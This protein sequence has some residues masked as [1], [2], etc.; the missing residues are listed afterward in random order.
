MS[1]A[2]HERGWQVAGGYVL[3]WRLQARDGQPRQEDAAPSWVAFNRWPCIGTGNSQGRVNWSQHIPI[4]P[5]FGLNAHW[6]LRLLSMKFVQRL[7][8]SES[9]WHDKGIIHFTSPGLEV[10]LDTGSSVSWVPG[11]VISALRRDIFPSAANAELERKH[12]PLSSSTI[13]KPHF[14]VDQKL[15]NKIIP[16]WHVEYEFWMGDGKPSQ[17]I[18]GPFDQFICDKYGTHTFGESPGKEGIQGLLFEKPT[19]FPHYNDN[20]AIFGINFFQTMFVAMHK[21]EAGNPFV[22]LAPQWTWATD[23]IQLPPCTEI[24]DND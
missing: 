4:S 5:T 22:R 13:T 16:Q 3:F 17:K 11:Y 19:S 2:D 24:P 18:C 14:V 6:M 20:F 21:P 15:Q 9:D 23:E 12:R 10:C 7:G 1:A 8:D